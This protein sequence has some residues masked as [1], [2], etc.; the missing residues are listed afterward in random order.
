MDWGKLGSEGMLA[1][2][3]VVYMVV[4][5]SVV[6]DEHDRFW[7]GNFDLGIFDQ[8]TWLLSRFNPF[9]TVRGLHLF[10]DHAQYINILV[11]PVFWVWD[12][13]KALLVAHTFAFALGMIPV[14]LIARE[15]FQNNWA[16][17]VFI[18]FIHAPSCGP[19]RQP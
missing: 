3:F 6:I 4:F 17:L 15:K 11:A 14:Y 5:C 1:L 10:G 13:V 12:D 19:L 18:S 2:M 9:L 7:Y 8:G 16:P